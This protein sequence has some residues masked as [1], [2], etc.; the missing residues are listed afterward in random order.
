M[1]DPRYLPPDWCG[2]DPDDAERIVL[3]L[4]TLDAQRA[5]IAR[6]RKIEEAARDW[7]LAEDEKHVIGGDGAWWVRLDRAHRALRAALGEERQ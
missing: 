4:H 3:Y 2:H 1:P 6:L 7:V 5:E